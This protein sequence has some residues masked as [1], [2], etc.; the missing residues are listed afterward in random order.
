ML[1]ELADSQYDRWFNSNGESEQKSHYKN[2]IG[3]LNDLVFVFKHILSL[4]YGNFGYIKITEDQGDWDKSDT[5]CPV[6][7]Y[8]ADFVTLI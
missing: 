3:N 5:Y 1:L 4:F 7:M 6:T 8:V 2:H